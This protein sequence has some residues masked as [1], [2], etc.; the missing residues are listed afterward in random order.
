LTYKESDRTDLSYYALR[1]YPLEEFD[2][3]V[4]MSIEEVKTLI[5]K[6]I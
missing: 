1:D 2:K 5:D 3:I 6:I 4:T